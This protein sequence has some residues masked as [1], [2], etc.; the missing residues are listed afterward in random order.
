VTARRPRLPLAAARAEVARMAREISRLGLVRGTAG[1]VSARDPATGYIAIT[2]SAVPYE[3]IRPQDV[4]VVDRRGEVLAGRYPPSTELP[5]H[6]ILYDHRPW[7]R[8]IVHT[9]SVY[10]T[11]FACL[12]QEIPPVH[13]L[14]AFVGG[15]IP[16]A[17]YAPYGTPELGRR[18]VEAL[19]D[20]RAVLLQNH[21]VVAVGRTVAEARILAEVVEYT[22]EVYHKA[23]AIGAPALVPDDELE[24]LRVRFETYGRGLPR[25]RE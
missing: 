18:A 10:A 25:R 9:H 7:A 3:S 16:V 2:P 12:G 24:R 21:G 13:Y 20:G 23:R 15:R 5:M 11:A 14:I 1:N 4:V 22:A 8:G 17:P 19:G 6:M